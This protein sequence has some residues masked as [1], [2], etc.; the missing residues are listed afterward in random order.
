MLM[1]LVPAQCV[2][3]ELRQYL[4]AQSSNEVSK[5]KGRAGKERDEL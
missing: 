2:V 5:R 1:L 3:A 4:D